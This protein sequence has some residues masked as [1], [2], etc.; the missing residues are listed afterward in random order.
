MFG[1][2]PLRCHNKVINYIILS[3]KQYL[4]SCLMLNK[5]PTLIGFLGHLKIK[6]NVERYAAIQSSKV[7]KFEKQWDSWKEIF[8]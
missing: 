2:A 6:S 3:M 8:D 5:V 7:H 4:F 1:E